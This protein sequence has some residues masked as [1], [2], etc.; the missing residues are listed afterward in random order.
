MKPILTYFPIRGR[1]EPIRLTLSALGIEFEDLAVDYSTMKTDRQSFPFG[2]CPRYQDEDVD[3]VQS[4]AIIRHLA[5]KYNLYGSSLKDN[6]SVDMYIDGVESFVLMYLKL[7]YQ[8]L[9]SDEAK[10]EYWS[11]RLDPNNH[12]GRNGGCHFSFLVNL[13]E[14]Y[15][16]DG[17]AVGNALTM[18]DIAVFNLVDLHLRLWPE[19][20][21]ATWP[22]LLAH[23]KKIASIPGIATYLS[24]TRRHE[25]VNGNKL[26]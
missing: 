13:L 23:H 22:V 7:I 16:S 9:L 26:G 4:N 12:I 24:S 3:M 1:G 21:P 19:E 10:E 11:T 15:G 20:L 25:Q 6:A 5:R 17:Y 8:E 2:Q 14:K 18:A